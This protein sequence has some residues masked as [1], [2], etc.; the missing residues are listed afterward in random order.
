VR[1]KV[2]VVLDGICWC[3]ADAYRPIVMAKSGERR[4][5]DGFFASFNA[6]ILLRAGQVVIRNLPVVA[7]VKIALSVQSKKLDKLD[8]E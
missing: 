1:D 3:S 5:L 7:N 8:Y 4:A 2:K 6:H